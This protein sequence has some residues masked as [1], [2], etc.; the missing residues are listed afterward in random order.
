MPAPTTGFFDDP[1]T[2]DFK[3]SAQFVGCQNVFGFQGTCS[4]YQTCVFEY[5]TGRRASHLLDDP[6]NDYV[7]RR[8]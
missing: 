3:A 2:T 1:S 7:T 5:V 6:D 8:R 4:S